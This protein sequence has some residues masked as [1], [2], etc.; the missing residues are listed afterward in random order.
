MSTLGFAAKAHDLGH[1]L[2]GL[3]VEPLPAGEA[4]RLGEAFAAMDPWRSYPYGAAELQHYLAAVEPAAPRFA[5]KR[6]DDLAGVLGLRLDWLRGPYLQFL[7]LL[8]EHQGCGLGGAAL[9]WL[10][11]EAHRGGARNVFV[12]V[13]DFNAEARRFYATHGFADVGP[14]PGLV[15]PG[16]TEILMRK[17]LEPPQ[18]P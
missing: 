15:Q 14:L 3:T 5:L 10:I 2:A 17:P 16:R 4:A 6:Y 7:G 18:A 8:P 9:R 11:A 12:C 13:S 1:L